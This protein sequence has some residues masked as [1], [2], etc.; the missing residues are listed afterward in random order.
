MNQIDQ[1]TTSNQGTP[2]LVGVRNVDINNILITEGLG[3]QK[4][5][6]NDFKKIQVESDSKILINYTNDSYSTH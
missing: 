1:V 5:L 4:V 3:L 2:L 6:K